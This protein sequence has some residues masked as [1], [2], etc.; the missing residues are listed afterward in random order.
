MTHTPGPWEA[1]M[2]DDGRHCV[3]SPPL[4]SKVTPWFTAIVQCA[5][6]EIEAANAALIAAAPDLLAA[7]ESA[8]A[9]LEQFV[10]LKAIPANNQGL[11]DARAAL[12]S[13]TGSAK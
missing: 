7:L 11:R 13:V 8:A 4:E 9:S 6:D 5:D 12:S 1:S 3:V 2:G 10:R